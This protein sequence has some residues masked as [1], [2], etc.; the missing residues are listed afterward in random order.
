MVGVLIGLVQGVLIR[1]INPKL[2]DKKSVYYGIALYAIGLILFAF[3]TAS[4]MMFAF[5]IPY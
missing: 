4:W 5:L 3:S 1:Y 2:G